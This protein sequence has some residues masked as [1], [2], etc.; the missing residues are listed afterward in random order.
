MQNNVGILLLKQGRYG[1]AE[2]YLR[3][4]LNGRREVLGSDDSSVI[5]S[6]LNLGECLHL[7]CKYDECIALYSEAL[8]KMESLHGCDNPGE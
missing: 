7:E 5:H 2:Q 3:L 1:V 4:A 6:L 8:Q